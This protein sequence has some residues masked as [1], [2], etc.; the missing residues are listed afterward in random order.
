MVQKRNTGGL[1]VHSTVSNTIVDSVIFNNRPIK[2]VQK[3]TF[4]A[5]Y[6]TDVYSQ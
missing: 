2:A 4:G 6:I 1:C 3:K 5:V